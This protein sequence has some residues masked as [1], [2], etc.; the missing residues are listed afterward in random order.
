VAG[1][2]G[3]HPRL[4]QADADLEAGDPRLGD[5]QDR[6][7]HAQP[8]ADAH[9]VVGEPGDGEV[10]PEDPVAVQDPAQ[11]A[12]PVAVGLQLVDEHGP[13]LAAVPDE[14]GLRVTVDVRPA[15]PHPTPHR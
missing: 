14:V 9:L 11:L 15:D 10:L 1:E 4:V 7:A 2:Q 13:L 6:A 5:L 8:V 12:L 3:G